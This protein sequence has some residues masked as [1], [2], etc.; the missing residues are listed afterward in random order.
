MQLALLYAC[1][2]GIVPDLHESQP[3][4]TVPASPGC[5]M[6]DKFRSD[7]QNYFRILPTRFSLY[8]VLFTST[9]LLIIN[10][11]NIVE[12]MSTKPPEPSQGSGPSQRTT[13]S[14]CKN[15]IRRIYITENNTLPRSMEFSESEY[16]LKA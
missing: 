5:T 10:L 2:L 7:Y 4:G 14:T 6:N 3:S 13:W 8:V 16:G 9:R 1:R 12:P 11:Q 15:E